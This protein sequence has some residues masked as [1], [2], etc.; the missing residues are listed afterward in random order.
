MWQ[1]NNGQQHS[2]LEKLPGGMPDAQNHLLTKS[3]RHVILEAASRGLFGAEGAYQI[4]P[5]AASPHNVDFLASSILYQV[6]LVLI[7]TLQHAV[8]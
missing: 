5:R 1:M 8:K 2:H 6:D 7:E 4:P 3:G